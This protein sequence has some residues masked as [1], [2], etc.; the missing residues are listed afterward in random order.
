MLPVTCK[1]QS[2]KSR[3]VIFGSQ[4]RAAKMNAEHARQRAKE[5]AVRP[6]APRHIWSLRMEGFGGQGQPYGG[7]R[8]GLS[9]KYRFVGSVAIVA[10]RM[11]AR[12]ALRR[13]RTGGIGPPTIRSHR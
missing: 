1:L 7:R 13:Q 12:D 8:G 6:N 3:E 4:V 10:V 9:P 5:A 11:L 2:T